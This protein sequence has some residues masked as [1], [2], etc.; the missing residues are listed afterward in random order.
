MV[1]KNMANH[2]SISFHSQHLMMPGHI[3]GEGNRQIMEENEKAKERKDWRLQQK[4]L[5]N[6][7]Q[8]ESISSWTFQKTTPSL[9][10]NCRAQLMLIK[11]QLPMMLEWCI[12]CW[13][14]CIHTLTR[15]CGRSQWLHKEKEV[16]EAKAPSAKL[17]LEKE[18]VADETREETFCCKEGKEES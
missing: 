10:L 3:V 18:P 7:P 17:L 1:N 16:A 5:M 9:L 15:P 8:Q 6:N 2:I 13:R 11:W 12:W 14:E 4:K